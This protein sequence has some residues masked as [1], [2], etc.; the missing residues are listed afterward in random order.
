VLVILA[1]DQRRIVHLAVKDHP[2]S[3]LIAQQL[4]NA[5]PDDHA[6]RYLVHNRDGAFADVTTTVAGMNIGAVRTAS[7]SPWQK[8]YASILHL[9]R[10]I[11]GDGVKASVR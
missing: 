7:H 1:H 6:P 4:R 5:F 3:G 2:T 10:L 9:I 8:D 11:R